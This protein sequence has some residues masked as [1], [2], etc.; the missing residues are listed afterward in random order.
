MY[1]ILYTKKVLNFFNL[2]E[3]ACLLT[4]QIPTKS[5]VEGAFL[6]AITY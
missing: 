1:E 3:E 6:A 4:E 2:K 5:I